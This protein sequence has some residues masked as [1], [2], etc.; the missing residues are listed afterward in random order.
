MNLSQARKLGRK[1]LVESPTPEL[2]TDCILQDILKC[3]RTFLLFHGERELTQGEE[4]DFNEKITRRKTGLPIAYIT[5]H[6]EFYGFDF[7]VTPSVLIPKPDTELLV[8]NAL[9]AIKKIRD[10]NPGGT[11]SICDI[12]T[13][14]GCVGLSI[15]K[16]LIENLPGKKSDDPAIPSLTLSDISQDALEIAEKNISHL[17]LDAYREHIKTTLGNLFENAPGPY[18]L[19][20]SNPP[21]I[22]AEEARELLT[23]GRSEP[24]L[25]LDGDTMEEGNPQ[26]DGLSIMRKLVPQA[27]GR[28][29][30]GGILIV[31]SGEYNAE[32]TRDIFI[33]SGFHDVKLTRDLSGQL[34]N[35]SGT[36]PEKM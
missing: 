30:P 1:L 5:G 23:D 24:I 26:S 2:D 7:L 22:P 13:G 17:G 12:C 19:I 6:K 25:A 27:Y 18:D 20:V 36:R 15:L 33:A 21:Y 31:E 3:D 29:S 14:S 9:E 35:T 16:T 11:I 8:E 34:R 10:E 32:K 28:L 4:E